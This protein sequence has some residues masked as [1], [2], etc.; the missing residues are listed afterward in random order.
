[1]NANYYLIAEKSLKK[2]EQMKNIFLRNIKVL[3]KNTQLFS[4]E[5][6]LIEAVILQ[7]YQYL[8]YTKISPQTKA[9]TEAY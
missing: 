3:V 6:T 7:Q 9:Q 4:S 2:K 8:D 1:M 5:V